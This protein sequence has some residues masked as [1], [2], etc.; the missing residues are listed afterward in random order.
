MG[1]KIVAKKSLIEVR[2]EKERVPNLEI[3]MT[4]LEIENIELCNDLKDAEISL[5]DNEIAIAELQE[6]M[7]KNA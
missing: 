4:D 5:T 2:E 1:V 6:R 7:E 3:D